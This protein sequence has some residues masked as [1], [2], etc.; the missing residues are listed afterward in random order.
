MESI[1]SMLLHA[2]RRMPGTIPLHAINDML[3]TLLFWKLIS[4]DWHLRKKTG[5]KGLTGAHHLF[6]ANPG[7][8]LNA[9]CTLDA[10]Q[11][12]YATEAH[13]AVRSSL[14][15]LANAQPDGILAGVLRPDRFGMISPYIRELKQSPALEVVLNSLK[16]TSIHEAAPG[17]HMS[18][19]FAAA[20]GFLNLDSETLPAHIANLMVTMIAPQPGEVICDLLCG[21]GQLLQGCMDALM[22][23]TPDHGLYLIG[24]EANANTLALAKMHL[25]LQGVRYRLEGGSTLNRPGLLDN[26]RR[27]RKADAVLVRVPVKAIAWDHIEAA[28]ES[29][30]RFPVAPPRDGRIA[31]VWH[32]LAA[33]TPERGRACC[34]LPRSAVEGSKGMPLRRHLVDHNLLDAVIDLPTCLHSGIE[35]P[36]IM[37][38]MKQKRLT[39]TTAFISMHS[40][41]DL[42]TRY[43]VSGIEHALQ[44]WQQRQQ[45]PWLR[46]VTQAQMAA[47]RYPLV[48]DD[49]AGAPL[50]TRQAA[51]DQSA[52][53]PFDKRSQY[54]HS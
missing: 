53:T 54:E 15:Q 46:R 8:V 21:D 38:L 2:Q 47:A 32:A 22:E 40:Q 6:P 35:V 4:E 14:I 1:L 33:M 51:A 50:R 29:L 9:S 10:C 17:K 12:Q 7:W 39:N 37:L 45:A 31:L 16:A 27:L 34:L 3:L 42:T 41:P 44:A 30:H 24:Q 5:G 19:I 18:E 43:D 11:W 13:L 36:Q 52:S 49:V 25:L 26:A 28:N 48:A 23:S 20:K